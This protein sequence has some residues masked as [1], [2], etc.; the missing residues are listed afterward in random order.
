MEDFFLNTVGMW[1][2]NLLQGN[3]TVG[4]VLMI[5]GGLR[6]VMKPVNTILQTYVK[7]T[8]YDSDDKWL[9]D[10]EQSKGY[11]LLIYLLDW[12]AS[13]KMPE[14]PKEETKSE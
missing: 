13:V 6:L 7:M 8:P 5:M 3:P 14:K 12:T 1:A 4:T 9:T 10:M 11:K 2:I